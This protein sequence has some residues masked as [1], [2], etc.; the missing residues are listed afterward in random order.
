MGTLLPHPFHV[1]SNLSQLADYISQNVDWIT[2]TWVEAIDRQPDIQSA[3]DL[4]NRQI[5]D[6]LPFLCLDLADRLRTA[7][8]PL[9]TVGNEHARVHGTHRWEQGYRLDEL[10]RETGIIR[11][12]FAVECVEALMTSMPSFDSVARR[13]AET[14]IHRFFDDM[15]IASAE[16]FAEE[17]EKA[18]G[19]SEQSTH[20]ILESALDSIVVM[21]DD[22]RIREF[23][24][25][26]ERM[27]G[28]KRAEVIGEMLATL[29]IPPE[30]RDQHRKG[31]AHYLATGEGP[32]LGR[33]IEVPALRA[34]G[35]RILV[36]LTITP[37][38]LEG[39]PVFTAYLR[40]IS[41]RRAGEEAMQRLASIVETSDDAIISKDLDGIIRSWNRGA[42][43]LLGYTA[44]E[45]VGQP[46]S[47]L[48]PEERREEEAEV[49]KR[50][51]AGESAAHY[52]TVRRRKDG[53][54]IDLS[55]TVSPIRDQ[56]GDVIGTSKIG[57][58]ITDRVKHEKRREAQYAIA[59]LT[60]GESILTETAVQLLET[61]GRSGPWIFGGLWL[62]QPDGSL[63]CESTWSAPGSATQ[64]FETDTRSRV[65]APLEGVP[66][67]VVR[68]GK[69]TW[70]SDVAGDSRFARRQSAEASGL[71]GA[72]LFPLTGSGG[73]NGV[74]EMLSNSVLSADEDLLRLVE[75]LGI[76]VGLY[77]ERKHT[78]EEL[79][80]QKDAAEA[81][82]QAKDRFLAALSHELRTPLTPVLMW[83]CATAADESLPADLRDDIRMVCR[84]VELEAR[85]IDDLLDLTRISQG[86][87]Q[88]KLQTCDVNVLFDHALEIVRSQLSA[89]KLKINVVLEATNHQI[90]GDPTRIQQVF[91]NLLKNAQK[92][93]PEGGEISV[94]SYD[95][96]AGVLGFE[97]SDT[98]R[99]IDAELMP[100]L[101]TAFEQ[102][103]AS[104]EGLGLGLAI[105]KSIL[106]MHG[107]AISARSGGQGG[108]ATFIVELSTVPGQGIA[109]ATSGK[110]AGQQWR[111][112]RILMVEDHEHTALVMNR[113][114]QRAGH[115]VLTAN[116]VEN[117]I[118]VLRSTKIDLLVS[119]LGLPDG[120]GFQVM[121]ELARRG[122][123]KGIAVSGYGMDEDLAQSSAAGFSAHL[124][125]PI[126]PE[127]L[128]QTIQ[129]VTGN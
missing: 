40:D 93:T 46:I 35:S 112:L 41:Q 97:I 9:S 13:R 91:W 114:L 119:D 117:A 83:A 58:D 68:S 26:A 67:E 44:E 47:L 8:D 77:I 74:V 75:A 38:R 88:L 63:T 108:G 24:P 122:H 31:L 33:R 81:A 118:G 11:H 86:K 90:V 69:A 1:A 55:L 54:I 76:Q 82:N 106:E 4:T 16:Q 7:D 100:K 28:F 73:P 60:S 29:I 94:R 103:A 52:D 51:H 56:N 39:K 10:I 126:S 124:T 42:E 6:H 80:R 78:E 19:A 21:G 84:N 129:E 64:E 89:K 15:L 36:E 61:I 71:H 45:A 18:L 85:L 53:S 48:I 110:T 57:R 92:F 34:D 87:L 43:R 49:T 27:F 127:Q 105:C 25:A 96:E 102:G 70:I 99:G 115:E 3:D 125:K 121:R 20:A 62:Q 65:L 113:L 22:G 2:K 50:L 101:F 128:E 79:H 120:N 59:T 111:K 109:G 95:A 17:K 5:V 12:V 23:N 72:L 32:L 104:T 98:G 116:S 66:G 30:F 107:G 14:V 37:Y 123:A